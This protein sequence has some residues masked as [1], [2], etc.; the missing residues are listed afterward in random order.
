MKTP[1]WMVFILGFLG[2]VTS[3]GAHIVAVNLPDY[4]KQVGVGLAMI[5]LLISAYDFAELVGKPIFGAMSDQFGMKRTMLIGVAVFTFASFLYPFVNPNLLLLV[6]FFTGRW[7]S[8]FLSCV[9]SARR[10]LL[11]YPAGSSLRHL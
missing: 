11:H 10:C 6:R 4:A 5:G 7:R 3:F 1:L 9:A 2:F 8:R